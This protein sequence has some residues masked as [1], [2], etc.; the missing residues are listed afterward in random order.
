[1]KNMFKSLTSSLMIATVIGASIA[2]AGCPDIMAAC[3]EDF[4]KDKAD[5]FRRY[6][7]SQA[8]SDCK[9]KAEEQYHYCLVKSECLFGE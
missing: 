9:K 7:F 2:Y 1:M 5:C 6:G 8:T 3:K 4:K